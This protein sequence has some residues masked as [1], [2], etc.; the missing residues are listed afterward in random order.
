MTSARALMFGLSTLALA[1]SV[2]WEA[3]AGPNSPRARL[4]GWLKD[5]G[6]ANAAMIVE[7]PS[8]NAIPGLPADSPLQPT[9]TPPLP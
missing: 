5:H 3:P 7:P 4:A 9:M 2:A 6:Y 8:P 1:A